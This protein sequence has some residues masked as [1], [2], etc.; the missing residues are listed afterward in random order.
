LVAFKRTDDSWH[1]HTTYSGPR[2]V[3]QL[4]YLQSSRASLVGALRHRLSAL[5]KPRAA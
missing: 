4:N 3:L 1:G 2:R 5:S